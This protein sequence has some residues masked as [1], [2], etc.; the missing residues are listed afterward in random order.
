[1]LAGDSLQTPWGSKSYLPCEAESLH[2][3]K[4]GKQNCTCNVID[5]ARI[6]FVVLMQKRIPIRSPISGVT[7]GDSPEGSQ[8]DQSVDKEDDHV[9][10]G[11][12]EITKSSA[13]TGY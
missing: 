6:L 1:M 2:V 8:T 4:T 3:D 9:D 10:N 11:K 13:T 7:G 5:E 12:N